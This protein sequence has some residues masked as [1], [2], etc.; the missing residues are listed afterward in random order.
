MADIKNKTDETTAKTTTNDENINKKTTFNKNAKPYI[1]ILIICFVIFR[2]SLAFDGDGLIS[3][4]FSCLGVISMLVGVVTII[5]GMIKSPS[6]NIIKASFWIIAIW[7][8]F[9][10]AIILFFA[11][12]CMGE[13]TL[14]PENFGLINLIGTIYV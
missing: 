1:I 9:S 10:I 12:A 4:V 8:I 5:T 11:V 2:L 6:S 7:A 13:K 3:K 14:F